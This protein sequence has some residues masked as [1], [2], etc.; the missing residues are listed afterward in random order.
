MALIC[1]GL[2]IIPLLLKRQFAWAA[3]VFVPAQL[4][5]WFVFWLT[6]ASTV[7]PTFGLC[8]F[9][10]LILWCIS[11]GIDFASNEGLSV[12]IAFPAGLLIV[13]LVMVFFGSTMLRSDEYA[14]IVGPM[15][16]RTWSQDI[17]PTNPQH[18]RLSSQEN[19]IYQA[20]NHLTLNGRNYG[21]QFEVLESAV[22]L[23]KVNGEYWYVV[24]LD[25]RDSYSVWSSAGAVP[26]YIM[27]SAE[28]D[29]VE[30]KFVVLGDGEGF[31][32]TPGA[33]FGHNLERHLREN[34]YLSVGLKD[35]TL[36]VDEHGK[37]WW[38]VT[39]Y[40]PTIVFDGE[41]VTGVVIVDPVTGAAK[42]YPLGSVPSWVDRVMP[43]DNVKQNLKWWG[44]LKG[45]WWN[46]WW[47]TLS[48]LE[49]EDPIMVYGS[50]GDL[51][52]VVSMT[53][54]SQK[55]TSLFAMVYVNSRTGKTTYYLTNGGSTNSAIENAVLNNKDVSYKKL[56]PVHPQI[57]NLYGNMVS[58]MP[59]LNDSHARQGV[60][61]VNVL[62]IQKVA[63]GNDLTEALGVYQGMMGKRALA[64]L[65]K[66]TDMK[67]VQFIVGRIHQDAKDG[68][69]YI[70]PKAGIPHLFTCT[71]VVSP[72][73]ENTDSGDVVTI[74]YYDTGESVLPIV[75]FDNQSIQLKQTENERKLN[76]RIRKNY[77]EQ[78]VLRDSSTVNQR[79]N[80]L[81]PEQ[82][83]RLMKTIPAN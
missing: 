36:E 4:L 15:Q 28:D 71:R 2:G 19:A 34:G 40:Q 74:G 67:T 55:D 26:G 22:T 69:F 63:I 47:G 58:V 7:G 38:V 35:Y 37:A 57:Y 18:I 65:E 56:H 68:N 64:A 16:T 8:G 33:F 5:L 6:T 42:P 72:K 31:K 52:W 80:R 49:P 41:K 81:T 46:S 82:R 77:N 29:E 76:E 25:Y 43:K 79:F 32:Y 3:G 14:A 70:Y 45:G 20:K 61:I 48:L 24:P 59:L 21:S 23:Q 1:A 13:A 9:F 51:Y 78:R 12:L 27:V 17:Q 39:T 11:A 73:I 62:E 75:S 10:V 60:A 44:E 66:G 54:T 50:D 83:E 53:S 30:P